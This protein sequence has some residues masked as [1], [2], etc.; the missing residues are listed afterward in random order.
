MSFRLRCLWPGLIIFLAACQPVSSPGPESAATTP[1]LLPLDSSIVT[2]QLDNG[3][4]YY[5]R[6]NR[7]PENRVELRLVVNAGSILEREDQQGLAHLVEHMAF[8]GTTHFPKQK[9]V[10]YLERIG[11]RFGAD[12]NAYTSFDETVYML[13]VPTEEETYIDTGLQ[14]LRDWAGDVAFEP[15]EVD[16]ERGVV[17]EEWRLGRGADARLRDKTLPVMVKD[18]RYAVRLPIGQP[19]V[20]DTARYETLTDFYHTWY[21]PDLM[22]VVVVGTIDP[23]RMESAIRML[24]SDL[25]NPD[26]EKPRVL[27]PVPDHDEPLTVVATD[28]EAAY[29]VLQWIVKQPSREQGSRE[30]YVS[31]LRER[32]FT[33]MFSNRLDELRQKPDSPFLYSYTAAGPLVRTKDAFQLVTLVKEGKIESA[34]ETLARE[35]E[36]VRRYGFTATEF[37][38]AKKKMIRSY[39][40][41]LKEA[42]KTES[43][44][45]AAELIR[46]FLTAEPVP[47]IAYETALVKEVLPRLTLEEVNALADQLMSR[48]NTVL[49]VTGMDKAGLTYPAGDELLAVRERVLAESIDPYVDRVSEAPLVAYLPPGGSI[50]AEDRIDAIDAYVWTCANGVRV[51]AKPTDFKNDQI[52]FTAF[53]PGGGSLVP[54]DRFIQAVYATGI[55]TAGGAGTFDRIQLEKKLSGKVVSVRP[56]MDDLWEGFEG[57][58]SREDLTTLFQLIWLY[59]TEPRKDSTAFLSYRQRVL[60]V[61][62]HHHLQPEAAYRDSITALVNGHHIRARFPSEEDIRSL[63]LDQAFQIYRDRFADF[64]DFT[65]VFVGS[66]DPDTLRTL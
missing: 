43:R 39:E 30:S 41:A 14:V 48:K 23:G 45:L 3:L 24:F 62:S 35:V 61:V 36:R 66:F 54:D 64:D 5:I 46:H 53:S 4:T 32:L 7:K 38:R 29:T 63:D 15:E 47:G 19:E 55:V 57:S 8:N 60:D 20:L 11:M 58:S 42:D 9:L 10:D 33:S 25:K 18:S 21:R 50:V 17:K 59:G 37:E 40:Q 1:D 28:P 44:S 6:P 49:A 13:E 65:F 31:D 34:L 2:G 22:A 51:C 26:P 56:Y 16:K 27:Y 52:L 12:V